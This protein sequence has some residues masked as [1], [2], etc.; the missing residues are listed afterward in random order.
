[1]ALRSRITKDTKIRK[2]SVLV[3]PLCSF[4][5]SV[6]NLTPSMSRDDRRL[7]IAV[8]VQHVVQHIVQT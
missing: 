8:A 6:V 3:F 5:S 1:M 2:G 7:N 4:V